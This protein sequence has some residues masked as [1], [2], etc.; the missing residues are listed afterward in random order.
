MLSAV[1]LLLLALDL[2]APLLWRPALRLALGL[3]P[4]RRNRCNVALALLLRTQAPSLDLGR[5]A[6]LLGAEGGCCASN[7]AR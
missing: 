3:G 1:V 5:F 4:R 6:L 2:Q 7:S